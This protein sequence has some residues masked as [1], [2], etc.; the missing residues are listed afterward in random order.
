MA[1]GTAQ[2]L[3]P[4]I[5]WRSPNIT[6]SKDDRISIASA[7]IEKA[8][9]MLQP[10]GQFGGVFHSV[11]SVVRPFQVSSDSAYLSANRLYAQMAEFDRLTNQTKYKQML[12]QWFSLAETA[13]SGGLNTLYAL[14]ILPGALLTDLDA[15]LLNFRLEHGY[16]VIRAYAAYQDQDFLDRAVTSWTFARQYTISKE[17]AASG[18]IDI[19]QFNI[20]SSCNGATM[21]GG[22]Y[23]NTDINN[24]DLYSMAS[25]FFL[26]VSALLAEATSNQTYLDAAIESA[27]FIQSHLLNPSSN[28]VW[29]SMSSNESC[30]VNT[31]E[32]SFNS[33]IFIGGLVILANITRNVSTEAFTVAAV[34]T[35]T[36][37]QGLDG[38]I[39]SSPAQ[40]GGYYI[41]Q[42][43][44]ALYER[45]TTFSDLRE[46]IKEYIGVQYNAVTEL[47]TSGGS[48]IYGVWTGPPST[49]FSS[50]NQTIAISALL[51]GVQLADDQPSSKSSDNPTST[52]IPSSGGSTSPLPTKKSPTGAIVG[53][54][55][56]GL[57]G[58]V[59]IIAGT[60][61][62]RRKRR[63]RNESHFA[64]DGSSPRMLTPFMD[65]SIPVSSETSGERHMN[66][67]KSARFS[68]AE[69]RGEPSSSRGL[70][71]RRGM[72]V[73][74]E[75]TPP[76]RAPASPP[77]LLHS[78][79][80]GMPTQDLLRLLSERLQSSRWNDINDE[81]PPEYHE[82]QTM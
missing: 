75:S 40:P 51:S 14:T 22:T 49:S 72:D 15:V 71:A 63:R 69:N 43:L 36:Q 20:A 82:G 16:A 68:L 10:D 7:A 67:T 8:V 17:Q 60:L 78:E 31:A 66:Q 81:L 24:T 64:V 57:A 26:A 65:T 9:S 50:D 52:A 4:A 48:N 62:L 77:N 42:A 21:A 59:I 37:W 1:S 34:A 12:K 44:A 30:S 35:N 41:V 5:S 19:K 6:S 53:G 3:T 27:N 70:A 54:V 13:D 56:A 2:D 46:Y 47:A 25:V 45:N 58:L 74:N 80:E 79:R 29:Y 55:V 23:Y 28:I 61:L 33:G 32:N 11:S 76:F 39:A 73:H 18:T 38:I